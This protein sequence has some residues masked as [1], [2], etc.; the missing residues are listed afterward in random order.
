MISREEYRFLYESNAVEGVYSPQAYRDASLAWQFAKDSEKIDLY[1]ILE[2]H[3]RLLKKVNKRIAGKI[4]KCAVWVGNRE[5]P[6]P[7]DVT[8]LLEYWIGQYASA[9]TWEEIKA[10]HIAFEKIHPF[11]DG[12]GRTGRIIMN[13]QCLRAGLPV[14][15]VFEGQSQ[16]EYYQWFR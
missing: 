6:H 4:R 16:Q 15:I 2:I 7:D 3:C 8:S 12:N 1:T 11:E 13:A 5:C 14:W 9:K 10:A